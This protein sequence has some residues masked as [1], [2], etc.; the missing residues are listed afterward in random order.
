MNLSPD[1]R[2]TVL[3]MVAEKLADRICAGVDLD[4]LIAMPVDAVCQMTG[5]SASQVRRELPT[6]TMGKRKLGVTLKTI[7]SYLKLK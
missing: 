2:E 7:K 6:R 5:L 3:N 4:E 1:D